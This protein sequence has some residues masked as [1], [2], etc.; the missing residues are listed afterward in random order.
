VYGNVNKL[1]SEQLRLNT[2][3]CSIQWS[4]SRGEYNWRVNGEQTSLPTHLHHILFAHYC[5]Y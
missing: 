4:S 5:D 3:Y 1:S 2:D